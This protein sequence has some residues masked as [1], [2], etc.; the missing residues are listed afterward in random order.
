MKRL[1]AAGLSAG[2]V[3][4]VLGP[5]GDNLLLEPLQE[6]AAVRM[7]PLEAYTRGSGNELLGLL[8]DFVH[9]TA[10][11]WLYSSLVPR[12]GEGTGAG[13]AAVTF[14]PASWV[15]ARTATE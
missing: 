1:I 11:A 14:V 5:L 15:G 6:A 9:G 13:L 7:R 10:S 2:G 3:L 12:C 4:D 8:P